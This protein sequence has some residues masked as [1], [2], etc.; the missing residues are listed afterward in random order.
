MMPCIC[1]RELPEFAPPAVITLNFACTVPVN[2]SS[3]DG[4]PSFRNTRSNSAATNDIIPS[5]SCKMNLYASIL[6][7]VNSIPL[8]SWF[9]Y[10]ASM[11]KYPKAPYTAN[12]NSRDLMIQNSLENLC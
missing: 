1:G 2:T 4:L 11:T 6:S 3:N 8:Y 9:A 12:D 10:S 7:T 5:S